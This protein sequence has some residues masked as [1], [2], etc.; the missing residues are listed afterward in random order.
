MITIIHILPELFLSLSIMFLLMLGVFVK[1]S[2]KLVNSLSIVS[3]L[4]A[5]AFVISQPSETIKIFND[6]YIIDQFSIFMK[7][8]TL[9]F[10][11]FVLLISK[12]Y[13][14]KII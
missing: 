14:K 1:K 5:I 13:I 8:L 3:L 11:I 2:F 6:S 7:I 4:I 9:L 12:D 10:C